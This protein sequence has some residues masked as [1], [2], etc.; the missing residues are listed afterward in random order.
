M[1]EKGRETITEKLKKLEDVTERLLILAAIVS[2]IFIA[3]LVGVIEL[4]AISR[5]IDGVALQ[6]SMLILGGCAGA[7]VTIITCEIKAKKK[8]EIL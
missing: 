6:S 4:Y 3:A 8:E 7:L 2:I 1:R 5:G